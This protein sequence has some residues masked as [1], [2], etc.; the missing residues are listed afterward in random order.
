[1]FLYSSTLL[2][3]RPVK[4]SPCLVVCMEGLKAG[5]RDDCLLEI[6]HPSSAYKSRL[7]RLA[8]PALKDEWL[9]VLREFGS[10]HIFDDYSIKEKIGAGYHS[11]I[12]KGVK[13][14]NGQVCA[15]KLFEKAKLTPEELQ[16]ALSSI[17][18]IKQL[19]HS[20]ILRF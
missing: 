1:M 8:T 16:E 3:F 11:V 13:R 15:I 17:E 6:T 10:H 4:A 18:V 14:S 7:V 9:T 19:T 2:F 5:R 12:Y 20:A